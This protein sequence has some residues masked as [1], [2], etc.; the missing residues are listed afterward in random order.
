MLL[1]VLGLAE[2]RYLVRNEIRFEPSLLE[3]FA[4]FFEI[5]RSESDRL[6]PFLPLFY[7]RSEGFWHLRALPGKEAIVEA[8]RT[9]GSAADIRNNIAYACLDVDLHA[10]VLDGQARDTLRE[11]LIVG[12]FDSY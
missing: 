10:L 1:G 7:L 6:S 11:D 3:R 2:S 5:V 4:R 8:M 9:V 12:W